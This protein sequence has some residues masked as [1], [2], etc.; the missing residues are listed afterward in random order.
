MYETSKAMVRRSYDQRYTTRYLVG[1]GIDIGAG[2][3]SIGEYYR[4]FP[5]MG[6]VKAWD[7]ADGDAMLMAG[8]ADQSYDFVHSSHCLEHL[9][10]PYRA[11]PNWVRLCRPG[12]HLIIIVP[13]EDL[14]EQGVWPS[15]FNPD[16]KWTFTIGKHQSWS[17][18][19]INV[20][21][22]LAPVMSEVAIL[23]VE[24][25][26]TGFIY[27]ANRFDQS[28]FFTAECAIQIILRR[29]TDEE[30]SRLGTLPS[31]S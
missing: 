31:S 5:L 1:N 26:D 30:R 13:D 27:H 15:T 17:P 24:L 23:R 14:Y 19:S 7:L 6:L 28:I 18:K 12:G 20:F 21:D 16:H 25:L 3:D 4:L 2:P 10:D 9:V 8:E 29:Y 11:L 22:L